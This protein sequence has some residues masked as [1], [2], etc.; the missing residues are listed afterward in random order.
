MTKEKGENEV[1]A[2]S[3]ITQVQFRFKLGSNQFFKVTS[4][5]NLNLNLNLN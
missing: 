1:G 4:L 2:S 5:L 3:I